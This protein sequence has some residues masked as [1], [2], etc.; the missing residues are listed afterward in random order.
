M[1][2]TKYKISEELGLFVL[3]D[4]AH[5]F[6]QAAVHPDLPG[7]RLDTPITSFIREMRKKGV[8]IWLLSQSPADF[9][10]PG[11]KM[12][13]IFLNVATTIMLGKADVDYMEFVKRFM[14]LSEEDTYGPNGLYWMTRHGQ[15]ILKKGN[16]PRSIPIQI[17]AEGIA[18]TADALEAPATEEN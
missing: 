14:K 10:S 17:D 1:A 9:L 8:A 16:D 13:P 18:K 3:I 5:H 6:S 15:G 4:E 7:G 2:F 12:S 11:E